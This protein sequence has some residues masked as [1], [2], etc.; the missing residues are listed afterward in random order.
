MNPIR[1]GEESQHQIKTMISIKSASR[2][3]EVFQGVL[4]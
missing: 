1:S 4:M 2:L 3:D